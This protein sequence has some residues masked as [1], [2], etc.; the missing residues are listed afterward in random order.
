MNAVAK[1]SPKQGSLVARMLEQEAKAHPRG[2][3]AGAL[4]GEAPTVIDMST[5]YREH[6]DL[7]HQFL[8]LAV[9]AAAGTIDKHRAKLIQ[10]IGETHAAL[11]EH[12]SLLAG[13]AIPKVLARD[14]QAPIP[15]ERLA[16]AR[17]KVRVLTAELGHLREALAAAEDRSDSG[18]VRA[19]PERYVKT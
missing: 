12:A 13:D 3:G 2:K 17:A 14:G 7:L 1:I 10:N 15:Y 16:E 5:W 4:L 11:K 18:A 6:I 9:K 8:Y 19:Q